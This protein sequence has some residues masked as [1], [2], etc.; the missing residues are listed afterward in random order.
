[1]AGRKWVRLVGRQGQ[2]SNI[3]QHWAF[4]SRRVTLVVVVLVVRIVIIVI[5]VVVV[6]TLDGCSNGWRGQR[7]IPFL[8]KSVLRGRCEAGR[9]QVCGD[10][11]R[12]KKV[13]CVGWGEVE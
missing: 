2:G 8:D 13:V 11:W 3:P 5:V 1:M 7:N 12:R 4:I 10:R 9:R 6:V